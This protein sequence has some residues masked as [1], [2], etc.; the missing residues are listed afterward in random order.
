LIEAGGSIIRSEI[1]RHINSIWNKEDLPGDWKEAIIVPKYKEGNK[2]SV[3]I[4]DTYPF[5]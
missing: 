2:K 3:V 5:C 4:T 1:N